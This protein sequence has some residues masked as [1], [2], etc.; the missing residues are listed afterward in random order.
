MPGERRTVLCRSGPFPGCSACLQPVAAPLAMP[1]MAL[2]PIACPRL[3][4]GDQGGAAL[5]GS[6]R[7]SFQQREGP[8]LLVRIAYG[9]AMLHRIRTAM[10][11]HAPVWAVVTRRRLSGASSARSAR[12][13]ARHLHPRNATRERRQRELQAA[14][15]LLLQR[16]HGA[17]L[18]LPRIGGFQCSCDAVRRA[19]KLLSEHL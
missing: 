3:G 13:R 10:C 7:W 12:R 14:S 9:I 17:R 11:R 18:C 16:C 5:L 8:V 19:G 2:A 6:V 15:V 1:D 4:C